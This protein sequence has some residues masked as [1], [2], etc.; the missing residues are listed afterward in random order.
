MQ[1]KFNSLSRK[2]ILAIGAMLVLMVGLAGG[3]YLVQQQQRLKSKA[4]QQDFVDAFEI[5]DANG[6]PI[7]C[8]KSVYP[9]VCT[10][11]TLDI[12]VRVKDTAPLLP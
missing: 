7:T 2:Q 10:T 5:K 11:Q 9:P 12:S 8:D 1:D 6:N 3:V 4:A